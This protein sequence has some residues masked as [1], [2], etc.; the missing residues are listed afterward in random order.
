M[1]KLNNVGFDLHSTI[2]SKYMRVTEYLA[3]FTRV[4]VE[5][6]WGNLWSVVFSTLI[7]YELQLRNPSMENKAKTFHP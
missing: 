2:K 7:F 4:K 1:T 6:S 5:L 3:G